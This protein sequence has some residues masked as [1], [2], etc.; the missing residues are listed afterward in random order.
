[1]TF[2]LENEQT[3]NLTEKHT[4][5]QG[6]MSNGL[7]S[8]AHTNKQTDRQTNRRTL[9]NALSPCFAVDNQLHQRAQ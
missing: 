7:D 8:R 6:R 3:D 2:D 4:K 1:M 5:N 9:P